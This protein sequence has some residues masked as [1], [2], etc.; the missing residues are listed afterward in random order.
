MRFELICFSDPL[1]FWFRRATV[2]YIFD[3]RIRRCL[4]VK[5]RSRYLFCLSLP[6]SLSLFCAV[7][8]VVEGRKKGRTKNE[9][10]EHMKQCELDNAPFSC[11]HFTSTAHQKAGIS[12]EDE[13]S[14]Y[15]KSVQLELNRRRYT[16]RLLNTSRNDS[17][18]SLLSMPACCCYPNATK[19]S[20]RTE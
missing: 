8:R 2:F 14:R 3:L 9:K 12:N 10:G 20:E 19:R 11:S 5:L 17:Y 1:T 13:H 4:H 18:C 15:E 6:R 16:K 7:F